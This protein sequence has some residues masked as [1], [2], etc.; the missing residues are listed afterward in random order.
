MPDI[1]LGKIYERIQVIKERQIQ[2]LAKLVQMQQHPVSHPD[3][4]PR[5]R[6]YLMIEKLLQEIFGD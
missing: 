6:K 3:L 2:E 5:V 4:V 1:N